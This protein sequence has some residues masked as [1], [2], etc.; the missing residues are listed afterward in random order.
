VERSHRH[1][2]SMDESLNSG[3]GSDKTLRRRNSIRNLVVEHGG[4]RSSIT[5]QSEGSKSRKSTSTKRRDKE[6]RLWS[7]TP[8]DNA[9]LPITQV[10]HRSRSVPKPGRL[11]RSASVRVLSSQS[12]S[13]T[14]RRRR[15]LT[16]ASPSTPQRHES[17]QYVTFELMQR[18]P[19]DDETILP[20]AGIT[21]T[22]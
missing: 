17:H 8:N 16:T 11:Q 7:L 12:S 2:S 3:A 4:R 19:L 10:A 15:S 5:D 20:L 13:L 14:P 22:G 1:V 18:Q 9:E 21:S 6:K